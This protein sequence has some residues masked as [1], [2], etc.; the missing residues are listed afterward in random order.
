M[1]EL[2]VVRA[3][4]ALAHESR[5]RVFRLLVQAGP[6]G[7]PAGQ[8]AETLQVPPSSLSFH[9]KELSYAGLVHTRQESR[10]IFYVANYTSMDG[11]IHYL[12][13]NCCGVDHPPS[14][15]CEKEQP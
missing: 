15:C 9:L 4:G 2:D 6:H 3:L 11:L 12:T 13:Q 14:P 8:L 5:L 10:F 7:V 1:E